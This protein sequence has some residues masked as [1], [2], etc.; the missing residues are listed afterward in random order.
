MRK[1]ERP[2][3]DIFQ[4]VDEEVRREQMQRLWR[5]YGAYAGA[6][7]VAVVVATAAYVGWRE[8]SES[9]QAARAQAFAAAID[10][11]GDPDKTKADAALAD[12]AAGQDG[13]AVLAR[14]R[15]AALKAEAEDEAGAI[16]LYDAIAADSSVAQ[17]FRD[18]AALVAAQRLVDSAEAAE[19]ERRL[20]PLAGADSPW[21]FSALELTALSALR[22]GDTAKAQAILTR[23]ADDLAAPQALR[24]RAAE[25]LA[26]LKE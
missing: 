10:L 2:V 26:S 3:A 16:A 11:I 1:T 6:L 22:A 7:A 19:I 5:R 14:F 18:A 12:L 9:R 25:L 15:Q 8:Y 23:L 4:E 21:R 20:G 17:P 24:A 13:F